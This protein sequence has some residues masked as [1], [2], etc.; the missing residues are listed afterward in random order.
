LL[1]NNHAGRK[2]PDA[3]QYFFNQLPKDLQAIINSLI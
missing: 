1:K 3:L 2:G